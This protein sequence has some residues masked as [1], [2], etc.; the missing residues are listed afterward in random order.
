[1]SKK[2]TISKL[3]LLKTEG[4]NLSHDHGY[5]KESQ[6]NNNSDCSDY[7]KYDEKRLARGIS[8]FRNN[9]FS[10]FVNMLTGKAINVLLILSDSLAWLVKVL[11]VS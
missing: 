2:Q 5:Y 11:G 1:M 10:M 7:L 6:N 9:F 3:N 8:F 4:R